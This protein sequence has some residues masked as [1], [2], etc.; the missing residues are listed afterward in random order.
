[1]TAVIFSFLPNN[2]KKFIPVDILES[3]ATTKA[4]AWRIT[5]RLF[6]TFL[7]ADK[8]N[9]RFPGLAKMWV[10]LSVGA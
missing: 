7:Q 2:F 8:G 10:E 3:N 4:R 9:R 6:T 1:M 5:F